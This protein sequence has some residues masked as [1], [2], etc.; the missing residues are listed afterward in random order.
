MTDDN[1]NVIDFHAEKSKREDSIQESEI[2]TYDDLPDE[3]KD[4]LR[5]FIDHM[6][7]DPDDVTVKVITPDQ[8]FNEWFDPSDGFITQGIYYDQSVDSSYSIEKRLYDLENFKEEMI[9]STIY[10]KLFDHVIESMDDRDVSNIFENIGK[11]SQSLS[12]NREDH[13]LYSQLFYDIL[14]VGSKM[15][16]DPLICL[17]DYL[18]SQKD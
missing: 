18:K 9:E 14:L 10:S 6:G 5:E 1:D 4:K 11:L 13:D 7:I 16:I 15:G 2:L 3:E 12:K 17:N 8:L